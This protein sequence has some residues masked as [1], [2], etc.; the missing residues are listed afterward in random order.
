MWQV[1]PE[2]SRARLI[3]PPQQ[4][5]TAEGCSLGAMPIGVLLGWSQMNR[6]YR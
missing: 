5:F 6:T 4:R 2:T 3:A 1:P